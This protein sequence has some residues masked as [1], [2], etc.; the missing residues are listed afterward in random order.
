MKDEIINN[1]ND[2]HLLEQLYRKDKPGFTESFNAIFD[3]IKH[4][5]AAEFWHYR[6][7]VDSLPDSGEISPG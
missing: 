7:E 3:S 2:A 6:L 4:L 5:P 1:I